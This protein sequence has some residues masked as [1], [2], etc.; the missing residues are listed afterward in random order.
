[1]SDQSERY[2]KVWKENGGF[3][4]LPAKNEDDAVEEYYDAIR[5]M[6]GHA[7]KICTCYG[8]P[9]P[10]DRSKVVR[11]IRVEEVYVSSHVYA[12]DRAKDLLSE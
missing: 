4:F 11:P 2:F 5:S 1:L 10:L 3:I 12:P 6:I 8:E 9:K 7:W